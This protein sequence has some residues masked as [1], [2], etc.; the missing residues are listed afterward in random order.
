MPDWEKATDREGYLSKT[1]KVGDCTITL[2][3]PILD[4]PTRE[5]REKDITA[6]LALFGREAVKR[7]SSI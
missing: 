7:C 2:Y 5:K 1:M 3:R 6:A 4:E